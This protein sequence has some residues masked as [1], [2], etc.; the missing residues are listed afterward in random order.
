[1]YFAFVF[2]V[3]LVCFFFAVD[4]G[5]LSYV[6]LYVFVFLICLFFLFCEL[7]FFWL[8]IGFVCGMFCFFFGGVVR[9]FWVCW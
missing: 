6:W 3:C 8:F 7:F 5:V 1:M 4:F 2:F 9:V